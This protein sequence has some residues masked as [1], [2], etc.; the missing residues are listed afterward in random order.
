MLKINSMLQELIRIVNKYSYV[1]ANVV[2]RH[3]KK[4]Q[5]DD[6]STTNRDMLPI[7]SVFVG[8]YKNKPGE[9]FTCCIGKNGKYIVNGNSYGSLSDAAKAVTGVRTEGW[10]FWKIYKKGPS[11]LDKIRN[12]KEAQEK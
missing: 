4:V 3:Y 9:I 1:N 10:R 11:I 2:D 7:G 5:T 6:K 8:T 12:C